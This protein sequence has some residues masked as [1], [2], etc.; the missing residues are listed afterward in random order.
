MESIY[1]NLGGG[2]ILPDFGARKLLYM[3][4]T[5]M[6][7]LILPKAYME[8]QNPIGEMLS[9]IKNR[10]DVCYITIDEKIVCNETHRREGIHV[11]FNWY[12]NLLAH[13][14]INT[15]GHSGNQGTHNITPP[16]ST[17]SHNGGGRGT[18]NSLSGMHGHRRYEKM[19]GGMLLISNHEGCKVYKGEFDGEIGDGGDCTAIDVSKMENEIMKPN[20]IY[21]INALGIHEPLIIKGVT[22]RILVRI[23]FHPNYIFLN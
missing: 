10:N 21:F 6:S 12:E 23:N 1:K 18:H 4:K 11:D 15:G 9:K 17:G 2:I 5:F 8:Y 7:D 20:N 3:H 13:G 16:P 19:E 14:E 22:E